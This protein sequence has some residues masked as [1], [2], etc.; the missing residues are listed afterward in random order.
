M[1]AVTVNGMT[2]PKWHPAAC[3]FPMMPDE[4]LQSLAD[5]IA[6]HGLREPIVMFD[7]MVLDGR[8]RSAACAIAQIIPKIIEFK[9]T[10]A[11]ALAFVWSKNRT[12]RHLSSSQAAIADAKRAEL[13]EQYK[14]VIVETAK[15]QPKNQHDKKKTAGGKNSPSKRD[16]TTRTDAQRAAAAGTNRKY[17]KPAEKIVATR[18]D[19]AEKIEQGKLTIPQATAEIKRAE[20]TAE[21]KQKA[22]AATVAKTGPQ[23]WNLICDDVLCGLED[24]RDTHGPARLIFT[25]PPYN[26]GVD[27]GDGA[28][29]DL[30][31]HDAFVSWCEEW[32]SLCKECLTDDGSLWLMTCDEVAAESCLILKK[33]GFHV[34]NW[35]KWYETFGVNCTNKFN[36]TSRHIFYATVHAR[37]FVWNADAVSRPSDRQAKYNDKRAATGGKIWDDVWQIPRLSGTCEERIPG[38]PTQ[39]PLQLVEPIVLCASDPGDLVVD[40]FNGS[41][42]TGVASVRNGRRYIGI[43]K[44]QEFI[45]LATKRLV[46][47]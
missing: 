15:A 25:D 40:P 41:G 47:T 36:R 27:Y 42:T 33:L 18:P 24:V 22:A 10:A 14:A 19:L 11:D 17:I 6:K 8:N 44:S 35:I 31:P 34:R 28:D 9:G 30:M 46:I 37:G 4:D 2:A 21:L 13:D 29:A 26:I 3:I 32:L 12:R 1:E 43:D 7:G 38:F 23:L 5:D 39:L 45:D 16:D 20:K